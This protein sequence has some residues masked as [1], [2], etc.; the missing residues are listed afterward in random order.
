MMQLLKINL[1]LF[2]VLTKETIYQAEVLVG[3]FDSRKIRSSQ[4]KK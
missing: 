4:W 3:I 1:D 2:E